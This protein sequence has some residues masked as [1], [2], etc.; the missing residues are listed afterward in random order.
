M[1]LTHLLDSNEWFAVLE[2]T[3]QSQTAT[4]NLAPGQASGETREAHPESDQVLIV[5][6]GEVLAEIGEDHAHMRRGDLVVIPAG[7]RH[8]CPND[9]AALARTISVYAP[10]AYGAGSAA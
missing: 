7:V 5:L 10:P 8:R 9:A 3:S 4:M 1:F 2:T 6:E